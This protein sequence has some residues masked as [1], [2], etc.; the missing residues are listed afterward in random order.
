MLISDNGIS[1]VELKDG[2][3]HKTQPKFLCDNEIWCLKTLF[4]SGYVP[5]AQQTDIET[6]QIEHIVATPITNPELLNY[7]FVKVLEALRAYGVR[8]GDLT[9]KNMVIHRSRPYIIDFAESRLACDPRE[10]KR[11]EGDEH[12]LKKTFEVLLKI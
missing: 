12:W 10:D 5:Y 11:P 6:I 9:E 4:P 7:H 2:W 8:H 1:K 3:I